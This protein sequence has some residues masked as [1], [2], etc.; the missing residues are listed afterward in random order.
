[1][2]SK[3]N[4][5]HSSSIILKANTQ[6]VESSDVRHF[7]GFLSLPDVSFIFWQIYCKSYILYKQFRKEPVDLDYK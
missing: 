7:D 2:N 1:M 6:Y 5:P 3:F 4:S